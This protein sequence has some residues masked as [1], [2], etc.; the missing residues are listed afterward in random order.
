KDH[1]Q[2]AE[3]AMVH[4]LVPSDRVE[5]TP[6]YGRSG[7]KLGCIERLMLDKMTGTVAYAVVKS[8][9]LF[10]AAHHHYPLPWSTLRYNAQR[11]S[12]DTDLTLDE[13]TSGPCEY[14]DT[15]DWGDRSLAEMRPHFWGV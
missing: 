3:V 6:V 10:A 14:D 2:R 11:K 12:Y 9:G 8:G 7:E 4:T 1:Q 15:F 13:L 5:G